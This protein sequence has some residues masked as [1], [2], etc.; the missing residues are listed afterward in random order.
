[1]QLVVFNSVLQARHG[2]DGSGL[3][4]IKHLNVMMAGG[5]IAWICLVTRLPLSLSPS[6]PPLRR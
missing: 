5:V 2:T 3:G 6:L 4:E 1:M